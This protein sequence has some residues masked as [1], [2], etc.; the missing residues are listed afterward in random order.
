[1][2]VIYGVSMLDKLKRLWCRIAGHNWFET[3]SRA[4][5]YEKLFCKRCGKQND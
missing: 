4:Y 1:V 3:Y 2:V 5:G